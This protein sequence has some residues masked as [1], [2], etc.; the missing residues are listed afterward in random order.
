MLSLLQSVLKESSLS[1]ASVELTQEVHQMGEIAIETQA[2]RRIILMQPAKTT[3]RSETY[4]YGGEE[5]PYGRLYF[6]D[7]YKPDSF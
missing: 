7:G 1:L 6:E 5:S 3:H 2:M 4:S